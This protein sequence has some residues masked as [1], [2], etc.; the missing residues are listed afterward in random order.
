MGNPHRK[1]DNNHAGYFAHRQ[2]WIYRSFSVHG[3]I[4][5]RRAGSHNNNFN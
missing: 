4:Y 1:A 5:N 3:R 2:F